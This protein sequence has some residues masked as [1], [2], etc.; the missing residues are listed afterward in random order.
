VL[1]I[2]GIYTIYSSNSNN[3]AK[4]I[5]QALPTS[6]PTPIPISTKIEAAGGQLIDVRTTE[7]YATS[8]ALGASNIPLGSLQKGDFSKII[9]G[10]PLYLYCRTGRRASEAKTILEKAGYIN[11]INIGGLSSW[12]NQGGKVCSSDGSSC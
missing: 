4:N 10:K 9:V 6:T 2:A 1:V 11:V 5:Q 12:Q 7:E 3:N 8:H